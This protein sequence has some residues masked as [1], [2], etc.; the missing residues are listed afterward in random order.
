MLKRTF[1]VAGYTCKLYD[2]G[3]KSY[4]YPDFN[5]DAEFEVSSKGFRELSHYLRTIKYFRS[6]LNP[7][8]Q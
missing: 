7:I 4:I 2:F 1:V 3:Y 8:F 5:G 6:F